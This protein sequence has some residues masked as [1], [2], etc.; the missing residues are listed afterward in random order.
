MDDQPTHYVSVERAQFTE[1]ST[2]APARIV[3]GSHA[4][5]A[6]QLQHLR[7]SRREPSLPPRATPCTH[8]CERRQTAV[9]DQVRSGATKTLKIMYD[10][11]F[12]PV[13]AHSDIRRFCARVRR[14][15]AVRV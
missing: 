13:F 10:D 8:R 14:P 9:A 7:T 11:Q 15:T 4:A 5:P 6:N 12:V 1:S 2:T 3:T